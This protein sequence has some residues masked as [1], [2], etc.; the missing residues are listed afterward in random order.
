MNAEAR[1]INPLEAAS[2]FELRINQSTGV[3]KS[4]VKAALRTGEMGFLHSFT[5]GS[6]VD[7]PGVRVVAWTAGC[8]WRCLYCH[9]PDTWNMMNGMAVTV[10]RA[11][12]ELRKYRH[13]LQMMGGGFTLTG[14]EPL[15]QD[16]F[17]VRLFSAAKEMG[18]HTA[19][20]TNGQLGERLSDEE[21]EQIDLVILDIKTWDSEAHRHLTGKENGPTLDFARRLAA[22]KRP[23]W[24]RLV[25]V[26]GLTDN[27]RDIA[28]I[29]TFTAG[30]GNVQRVDVLPF[31]QMGRYKWKEL[32]IP[33]TLENVEAP[34]CE[35]I[36]RTAQE[37]WAV[38]L[39]AY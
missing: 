11:A 4:I 23:V 8:H 29:A 13:G 19:L 21:L 20:N 16:R 38:G 32:N 24:T 3:A 26:P 22:L 36:D 5:T 27:E 12:E 37:F 28:Q 25:V 17:A 33:Y 9:N 10:A 7:G 30:L 18:I 1:V 39:K 14:G 6:T 35:L 2:P 34:G 31:H 15:M